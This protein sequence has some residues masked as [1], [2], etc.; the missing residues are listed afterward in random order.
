[1][2]YNFVTCGTFEDVGSIS[3]LK[4]NEVIDCLKGSGSI[5]IMIALATAHL[6]QLLCD[7]R[8]IAIAYEDVTMHLGSHGRT[9][10]LFIFIF[11][12]LSKAINQIGNKCSIKSQTYANGPISTYE[13]LF[14]QTCNLLNNYLKKF[15]KTPIGILIR[16]QPKYHLSLKLSLFNRNII[17]FFKYSRSG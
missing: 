10:N 16:I 1:M 9:N 12:I 14:T 3:L 11:A 15:K 7:W 5:T 13:D 6:S 4:I 8:E 2:N 17:I